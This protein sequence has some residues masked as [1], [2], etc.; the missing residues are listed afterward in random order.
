MHPV[1]LMRL[2]LLYLK[3]ILGFHRNLVLAAYLTGIY[4]CIQRLMAAY[5]TAR[6]MSEICNI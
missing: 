5:S 4:I 1:P 3:G 6:S 2:F